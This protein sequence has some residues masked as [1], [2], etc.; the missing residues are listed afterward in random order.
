MTSQKNS[1]NL[2]AIIF[3]SFVV[4]IGLLALTT[5]ARGGVAVHLVLN[6]DQAIYS[7]NQVVLDEVNLIQDTDGADQRIRMIEFD[8]QTTSPFLALALPVMHNRG[9]PGTGDDIRFWSFSSRPNCVTTPAFCG[10]NHLI[11]YDRAAGPVDTRVDML[12]I[13][14][15]GLNADQ[16]AQLLLPGDGTPVPVGNLQ[17]TMPPF[18]GTFSLNLMNITD[19]GADRGA[20]VDLGFDPHVIWRASSATPIDPPDLTGG[21]VVFHVASPSAIPPPLIAWNADPLSLERTTRSLRFG[22]EAPVAASAALGQNAIKVTMV[23]LHHPVPANAA[24]GVTKNFSAFDT[25]LNGLCV[26]GDHNGHHCDADADCRVCAGGSNINRV[27]TSNGDCPGSTCPPG[28]TCSNLTM[29]TAANEENNCARWV[30]EPRTYLEAQDSPGLGNYRAA[31]LQCTPFYYDWIAEAASGPITVFG[32]EILPSSK[33]SVQ[34]YS[35][36]CKGAEGSCT[37]VST[38]VEMLTRRSGD[39]ALGF[40]PPLTTTQPDVTDVT[41]LVDKSKKVPGASSNA[42]TLIQPNLPELNGDVSVSDIV[43]GVDAFKQFAYPFSGPCPCPSQAQC[44]YL[45]CTQAARCATSS[46]HGLGAGALCVK[47]CQGGKNAGEPCNNS[48]Q[49]LG[50]PC[51]VL[52]AKACSGGAN[53]G[54]VCVVAGDCPGGSCGVDV[55]VGFCRDRCGRCDST[56]C[57]DDN[58][59]TDDV[60][61]NESCVNTPNTNPCDDGDSCTTNDTCFNGFCISGPPPD[62]DDGNV[63]TDDT[64]DPTSGCVHSNSTAACSDGLFCNGSDTCSDGSCSI[65]SGNPCPPGTTCNGQACQLPTGSGVLSLKAVKKNGVAVPAT[66]QSNLTVTPNDTIQV[67]IFLSDWVNAFPPGK[68]VRAF[69]VRLDGKDSFKS[70]NNGTILPAGWC[71]TYEQV[72][73]P[74]TACPPEFPTCVSPIPGCTCAG[75]DPECAACTFIDTDRSDF[76]LFNEPG[77]FPIDVSSL[78]YQYAGIA[79]NRIAIMDTGV[80]RY[81]A[82]VLLNVSPIACGTFTIDLQN[83]FQSSTYILDNSTV[84]NVVYPTTSPLLLTIPL[85]DCARQLLSCSPRHCNEDARIA[86]D[87]LNQA[88]KLNTS[89]I[90]ATFSKPTTGMT[91]SD[92]EVTLTPNNPGDILPDISALISNGNSATIVLNREIQET[93]WTCIRDKLS[94]QRCCIASLPSDA[95]NNRYAQPDDTF[96][97]YDNLKGGINPALDIEKCDTD[98]STRCTPHDLLMVVDLLMGAGAFA[99]MN[100]QSLPICPQMRLTP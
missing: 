99:P 69:N 46:A 98:R 63:C 94:N 27:C 38:P 65:H 91:A 77:L 56:G 14:F 86:H 12:S 84:P 6:P 20:Q 96:E 30:G 95:D 83:G 41:Q 80:P 92:F 81:I 64:C 72:L 53:D 40:N 67:E 25:M 100:G 90:V 78:N 49:C 52:R 3:E 15:Q 87:R 82:T 66:S 22:V 68:G 26:G 73:C 50:S 85:A 55:S 35:S 44:D 75:H 59:C 1:G 48:S 8:L 51:G 60:Y 21:T 79:K 5:D 33:Y 76:V 74:S 19:T 70:G 39:V 43:Q 24:A 4:I 97:I 62:C 31:R 29:C 9:T 23:D 16:Q 61:S 7:P 93:R 11:D 47:T 71:A 13:A 34:T 42:I 2:R 45:N 10:F 54:N 28:G 58:P 37:N 57:A 89:T 18:V 88:V 32:A 17:V 36:S